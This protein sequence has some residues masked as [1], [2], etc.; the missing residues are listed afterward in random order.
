M[1]RFWLAFKSAGHYESIEV[2]VEKSSTHDHPR[3]RVTSLPSDRVNSC[4]Q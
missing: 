3:Y 1:G 4:E 2:L